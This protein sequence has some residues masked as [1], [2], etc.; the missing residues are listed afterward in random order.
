MMKIIVLFILSLFGWRGI[1]I[2]VMD[3]YFCNSKTDCIHEQGHQL[4]YSIGS[5]SQ[6]DEFKDIADNYFPEVLE[7]TTCIIDNESCR[8]AEA[9]A[10]FW[11]C[12]GGNINNMPTEF[13]KFYTENTEQQAILSVA[14]TVNN[15]SL[16]TKLPDGMAGAYFPHNGGIVCFDKQAC[17]HEIGHKIDYEEKN[18]FSA[19][20]EWAEIV[21][22]YREEIYIPTE[23]SDKI[24][25]R[26]YDFPGIGD[27]PCKDILGM[28]WGGYTELYAS[29][30]EHSI[31]EPENMPEYFRKYYNWERIWELQKDYIND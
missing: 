27:N 7:N 30:L 16:P 10:I 23:D 18:L 2:P 15:L 8:Y 3:V 28:C 29:I 31:S 5:P 1:Y 11:E 17:L 25:N 13:K 4:D 14:Q 20:E 19:T 24:E 26:I 6:S 21:E 12:T 22:Y 9:Y